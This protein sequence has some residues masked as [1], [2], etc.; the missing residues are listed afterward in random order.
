MDGWGRELD[1]DKWPALE[2]RFE[3]D[4]HEE[5]IARVQK[6]FK[7]ITEIIKENAFRYDKL[8]AEFSN[9][10]VITDPKA[11]NARILAIIKRDLPYRTILKIAIEKT[12]TTWSIAK[13]EFNLPKYRYFYPTVWVA[14]KLDG[15]CYIGTVTLRET[16]T[17][18]GTYGQLEVGFTSASNQ[19]D[20][21]IDCIK[22]K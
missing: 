4:F 13:D 17:G 10:A 22:V 21:G 12:G 8:P 3:F 20:R 5:D 15:K 9:S 18:G 11:S 16:Y 7:D 6:D 19:K 2:D 14:Y 1:S